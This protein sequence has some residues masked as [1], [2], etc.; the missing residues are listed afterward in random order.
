MTKR[1]WISIGIVTVLFVL[2]DIV[3][4][5]TYHYMDIESMIY[6]SSFILIISGILFIDR[7]NYKKFFGTFGIIASVFVVVFII[8]SIS[9]SRL[10]NAKRYAKVVGPVQQVDFEDLYGDDHKVEM[11][12]VDKDSAIL[13]AEKKM[14]ELSDVSSKF[15]INKREFAQINYKGNM[16]RVAPFVYSD[17]FKK[18]TNMGNGVPYYALVTTGDGNINAKAEI[19]KL[20][21]PMKYYPGAPL[22]YDL[23][24]HVAMKHKFSYLDGWTFEIDESGHPYWIVQSITKKVGIWGAKDM[25]AIITVDAVTGSTQRYKL[26]E[27][28]EWVDSVYPTSMLLSQAKDHYTLNRGYFNSFMQQEG[29]MAIDSKEGTYNYVSVDDEIYVFTGIRPINIDASSTTGL[30]FLNRHTGEAMEL[31]LPGI[32]LTSAETTSVGSIQEKGYT[33]TT[34][35]LQNVGG[36]PTYVTSLKDI[37]G[38]V[39]SLAYVNYQDYTKSAVGETK[40][41]AEKNYLNVMGDQLAIIG[42]KEETISGS[43][44]AM[45]QVI[46]DGNTHFL[47]KLD[48]KKIIFDA[49]LSVNDELA[50]LTLG[51]KVTLKVTGNKILELKQD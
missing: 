33:P 36:H 15:D 42:G 12:Y 16:V 47:I 43:I 48:D 21:K 22:Q 1:K 17:T 45:N 40:P 2:I 50:F 27:V 13:A 32:S 18:Y 41:I 51:D 5:N 35:T 29:V 9:S 34:P 3:N 44:T 30:L 23:K 6:L 39:R 25:E 26:D 24:R 49:A 31:N 38:V 28:P 20:D 11:S 8:G 4:G 46:I 10:I 7:K 14:G 19:V 37:S